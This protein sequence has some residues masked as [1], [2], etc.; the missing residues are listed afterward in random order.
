MLELKEVHTYYG[1][2]HALKGISLKVENGEIVTLIGSN[3]AGKSTTLRTIQGINRPRSG[4][5]LLDGTALETL[6]PHEIAMRG[7]AQ[8]P[9]GRLIFPRMT[10]LENL[11]MGAYARKEKTGFN[12]DLERVFTLFPR[13]KERVSQKGGTLSGGEAQR[14]RLA[15]QIGSRLVG[16]LYILDEPTT[17]LHFE[18]VRVLLDVLNKLVDKGN[19]VIIIEHNME[20][21]KMADHIIDIGPEGG[22]RG[23]MIITQGTPEETAMVNKSYTGKFLREIFK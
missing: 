22:E 23:G 3:G 20:V 1:N 2:I 19:T 17:G 18:D 9:E 11:E 6:P 7:V 12:D 13:L 21:I 8:S 16:T 14:I 4:T 15:S 5:I 10:V